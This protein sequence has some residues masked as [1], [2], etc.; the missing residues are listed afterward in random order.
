MSFPPSEC[1]CVVFFT[2]FCQVLTK[3]VFSRLKFV[4]MNGIRVKG[5]SNQS[6]DNGRETVLLLYKGNLVE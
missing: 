3:R 6:C 4:N 1:K 5:V 2:P